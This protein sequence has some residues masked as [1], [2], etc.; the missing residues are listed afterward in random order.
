[1]PWPWRLFIDIHWQ[2]IMAFLLRRA[3]GALLSALAGIPAL[4]QQTETTTEATLNTVTV[5]ASPLGGGESGQILAPAKVLTGPELR[6]KLGVSLGDTLSHELGVSSSGFGAGASRPIIRGLEGP[7]IKVLENGMSVSDVSSLSNDHAVAAE[8]STAR[9]IEILR[10]P[11]SL[12]YGSGAVGGLINIVNERIPR[13][14]AVKPAGEA[15]LRFGTVDRERSLS[16]SGDAATGSLGLHVDASRRITDDY[17]IPGF[18]GL[19]DPASAEGRLPSSFTRSH[20]LGFGLSRI[21]DW[22]YAGVSVDT[23]KNRY[24]IPTEE[25]SFIDLQQ[26]RFS[27]ESMLQRPF[28]GADSLKVKLANSDYDH[29][30]RLQDG[31]PATNFRNRNTEA[32]IELTHDPLMGWRGTVGVQAENSRF[33]ALSAETG[34]ANTVPAT[35]STA[36]AA[37]LVEEKDFGPLRASTGLRVESVSRRPQD[38]VQP[39]RNFTLV[40]ASVGGLWE[41]QPGFA[42]GATLS[43]AQRAPGIEELYSTGPHESTATF[44]IGDSGLKKETSR[45]LELSLQKTR[46]KLRW[47]TNLFENRIRNFVYGRMDGLTVDEA[48]APDTDGEFSRRFWSQSDATIRGAEAE[49]SWNQTGQGASFRGFA[50]TSRGR[51]DDGSNL[52]L[53]PATRFGIEAGYRA[54]AWRGGASL[55]RARQQDRLAPAETT[56]TPAY[57]LLDAN[58]SYTVKTATA[59][60]TWFAIAKNLLDEDVRLST[61]LLRTVAPQPGRNLVVG[62]RTTF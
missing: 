32:R 8:S 52:P 11:A 30:E 36:I 50:D 6:N 17:R 56:A 5:T 12:L 13:E 22:G 45:N 55:L 34:R 23:R 14:L 19:G 18:A 58:L 49:I 33:S 4:A 38:G 16:L 21:G 62:V 61:S 39:E 57:T 2:S 51:L 29:T 59:D 46:G 40:S 31:T 24:G 28:A 20:T 25:Q 54:G 7:R 43:H 27:A 37:F 47:K 1:V 26:T 42:A 15:E 53:Q 10:G 48:G 41:F 60:W 9:Q 35:G 3:S 44:D